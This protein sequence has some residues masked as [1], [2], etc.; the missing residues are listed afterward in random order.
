[1]SYVTVQ[2]NQSISLLQTIQL[3]LDAIEVRNAKIAHCFCRLIP[4]H[5]PFEQDIR[6]FGRLLI[7]IP[8][9]CKLNPFYEQLMGLRFKALSYL[10][11]VCNED[12][13]LYCQ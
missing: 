11:D 9:L 13:T 1:M 4:A 12:I 10:A 3:K 8:S 5:C 2:N 6:C 7:H